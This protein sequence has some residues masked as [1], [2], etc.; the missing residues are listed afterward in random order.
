M[1]R[2]CGGRMKQHASAISSKRLTWDRRETMIACVG[3][4]AM[5]TLCIMCFICICMYL[6]TVETAEVLQLLKWIQPRLTAKYRQS[7]HSQST[8]PIDITLYGL[9]LHVRRTIAVSLLRTCFNTLWFRQVWA[10]ILTHLTLW[11]LDSSQ[12]PAHVGH[13]G[14]SH[15]LSSC[16][17]AAVISTPTNWRRQWILRNPKSVRAR[18]RSSYDI[19][20]ELNFRSPHSSRCMDHRTSPHYG[21][22]R[23]LTGVSFEVWP[24][25]PS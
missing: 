25:W 1:L 9:D 18:T 22:A 19:F 13:V 10:C 5:L 12:W 23:C 14:F 15:S 8:Y 7:L 20:Y 17:M 21:W 24:W 6:S 4:Q 11:G 2:T 3:V 16:I